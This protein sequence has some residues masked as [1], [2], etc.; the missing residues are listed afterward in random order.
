MNVR[1]VQMTE[2][3]VLRVAPVV[4]ALRITLITL[5]VLYG[6][7]FFSC[8]WF[9]IHWFPAVKMGASNAGFYGWIRV[10]L[11]KV[12][13]GPLFLSIG[14]SIFKLIGLISRGEPFSLSSPT[15]IRR[16][17]YAIFGLALINAI[18]H[19]I[20]LLTDPFVR[21]PEV[22]VQVAYGGLAT[23]LLGFGFLVI[24]KVLEVGVAL[25]Q[26]QDLTV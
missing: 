22:I 1:E 26:D 8:A 25:R 21:T 14:L 11:G 4:K 3:K 5:L 9:L 17:G 6:V 16:I 15:H 7:V 12:L 19:A 20:E 24:A 2:N 10:F 13:A 18:V 23:L